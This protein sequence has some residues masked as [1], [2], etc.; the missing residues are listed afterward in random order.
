MSEMFCFQ[1]EQTA[2]G[3]GCTKSGVCGKKPGTA[4]LQ[5]ML[6]GELVALA[7]GEGFTRTPELD[8][9]VENALFTTLTN[10]NF[11]DLSLAALVEKVRKIREESGVA[12]AWD[13]NRLWTASEDVRSLKSLLLFGMKG[14][15][16]YASHA[17]VLGRSREEVTGFLYRGLALLAADAGKE[18]LLDAVLEAGKVN[19]ACMELLNDANRT[20]G[21]PEPVAVS[22]TVER[23]PFIIVTVTTCTIW[24]CCCVRPRARA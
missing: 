14:I 6:V 19:L 2:G 8:T 23:G 9:L 16:A 22:R 24:R 17:R 15:A 5:D 11:D 21:T 7:G 20:Y 10:V 3:K 4:M 13:M 12:D 1:C 18:T